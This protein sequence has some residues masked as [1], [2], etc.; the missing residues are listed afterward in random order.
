VHSG[1]GSP[2]ASPVRSFLAQLASRPSSATVANQYA[3]AAGEPRLDNLRRYL[4]HVLAIG[5][6]A[7]L[8][9]EA[10][11]YRGSAVTGVPL[12]SRSLLA[13]DIGHWQLFAGCGFEVGDALGAPATEIT[14]TVV[15]RAATQ[16]LPRPHLAW[17]AFPFHPHPA[18]ASAANR[19]LTAAELREGA[20]FLREFLSLAPHVPVM[21]MGRQAAAALAAL[22]VTPVACLRHPA[23]GGA[24]AFTTGFAA[25]ARLLPAPAA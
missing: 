14:A 25:A 15:W 13:S 10:P 19:S 12:T 9:G 5:P 18:G 21:A 24:T 3:G 17:N 11:G 2:L 20:G 1:C 22:G 8:I 6:S 16:Y 7:V 23:H 4:E